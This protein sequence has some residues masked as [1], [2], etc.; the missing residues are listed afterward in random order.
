MPDTLALVDRLRSIGVAATV[1][2]AGPSVLVLAAEAEGGA[3]WPA[4]ATEVTDGWRILALPI[5][6]EGALV[7]STE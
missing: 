6:T 2:G 3:A 4:E 7:L 5:D 1:S